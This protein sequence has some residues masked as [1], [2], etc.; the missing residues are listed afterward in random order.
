MAEPA[1]ADSNGEPP[2]PTLQRLWR[3]VSAWLPLAFRALS[4]FGLLLTAALALYAA[5][6][7]LAP[8][9][10][11]NAARVL[12]V[13]FAGL[14]PAS[15]YGYFIQGRLPILQAEYKQNLRRLG[16]PHNA[17]V[18]QD[19]FDSVYGTPTAV[20]GHPSLFHSPILLATLISILG[21]L[22]T[23]FP[24]GQGSSE[25]APRPEPFA[26]AFMGAYVFGL[27]SLIRQYVTD[28]L[29]PRYYASLIY[30]YLVVFVLAWCIRLL[31]PRAAEGAAPT[32]D[33]LLM[34]AFFIG[35]FPSF[36]L[37]I[38]ERIGSTVLGVFSR[39]FKETQPLSLLDGLNAYHEDRLLLEGIESLQ[40]LVSA[41]IVDLMLK[42]RYPV[43]QII[44]WMDQGLLHL[45]ARDRIAHF[46]RCGLRTATDFLDTHELSD[47]PSAEVARRRKQLA[48]LL[49]GQSAAASGTEQPPAAPGAQDPVP[50]DNGEKT[51]AAL[52]LGST[53]AYLETIAAALR[54]D[55]NLFHIRYWRDHVYEALPEDVERARTIADLKLMQG[56]PDEAILAYDDLVRDY[57]NVSAIL[58]YRGLAYFYQGAYERAIDDYTRAIKNGGRKWEGTRV[59]YLERGRALRQMKEFTQ[60]AE[61]YEEALK[62]YPNFPEAHLELALVQMTLAQYDPAIEHLLKVEAEEYR[63]SEALAALGTARYER[64]KLLGRPSDQREAELKQSRKDHERALRLKPDL[65]S[66]SL[67]LANILEE[68]QEEEAA[69]QTLSQ[70]LLQP[71][72]ARD[73]QNAYR[74]RL[75][76]GNLHLRR[77]NFQAAANDYRAAAQLDPSDAAA[78]YNSGVALR[79][80]GE[81]EPSLQAFRDATRLNP[82]HG[83]AH[84]ARGEMAQELGKLPEAET[85]YSTALNLARETRDIGGQALA[86]LG[87]GKLYRRL[88][89]RQP[90]A[91]RELQQA[92]KLGA[93]VDDLASTQAAYELGLLALDLGE[94]DDALARF[95]NSAEVFEL[96]GDVRSSARA[97][98]QLARAYLAQGTPAPAADAL[99]AARRQLDQVFDSQ[100]PGDAELLG[101]IKSELSHASRLLEAPGQP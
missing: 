3:A 85:A 13:L 31:V 94:L 49:D 7:S 29:Q 1:T 43:E 89:G 17:A 20:G 93:D 88:E 56:L 86:R 70:A 55:P 16:L 19:K 82:R 73:P 40:N 9:V 57:P 84:Q 101:Q 67:Y 30:R 33:Q 92:V 23:F 25:F 74:A 26:Y 35:L 80:L 8:P 69:L 28:D 71:A 36:G 98:L 62:A 78:F 14:M 60:A 76:R 48:A 63:L 6:P 10:I 42:T 44:D 99:N 95:G 24:I 81:A 41:G 27:G 68:L 4:P 87:L 38:A 22:L 51:A 34:A 45:H 72:L 79:R 37:R 77:G 59:A 46:H 11:A 50:E 64:W 90:D 54:L 52:A 53:S 66:A 2:R 58:L 21:W 15:I 39:R 32:P 47:L 65:T 91:L 75:H 83:P 96:L 97:N 61:N 100:K 5:M 18:Y 12:I